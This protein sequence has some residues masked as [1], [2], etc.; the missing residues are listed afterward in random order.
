VLNAYVLA[1][2]GLLLLGAR[3]GDLL[4][5][6][7]TFLAGIALFS[8]GSLAGGLATDS[9]ALLVARAA[10]GAGGALVAPSSLALLTAAFPEGRER[11]RAIGLFTT[12]SAAGGAIGLIAGGL[13]VQWASW[14]WVMFVNVPIGVAVLLAGRRVLTETPRRTGRFDLAGAVLSTLGMT[15]LVLGLVEA[16]SSGW[17]NPLSAGS[18][19]LGLVLLVLFVRNEGRV[20]EPIVPLRLLASP[21]RSAANAARGLV[22]AGMYGVFFFASQYLQDVR[23]YSPLRTGFSFLVMPTTIFLASQLATRTLIGRVRPK[24]LMATGIALAALG[25]AWTSRVQAGTPY[26]EF[27]AGLVVL[28]AGMGLAFVSLTSASL[29]DVPPA[30]AGAASGLVN[31]SQQLGAALGLAAL[32]TVFGDA[33]HHATLQGHGSATDAARALHQLIHGLDSAFVAGTVF[34]LVALAAVLIGVR[35]PARPAVAAQPATR[36][37]AVETEL[38][39]EEALDVTR[40]AKRP[41]GRALG[42]M[43]HPARAEEL[44]GELVELA[45]CEPAPAPDF[46]AA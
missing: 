40:V 37:A 2:G 5:R 32:V 13:L 14:R 25:L 3:S 24:A 30:D 1:F 22:Y 21:T 26:L 41:A 6:R 34:A 35:S 45:G 39:L 15:G 27:E 9:L 46:D 19:A 4:G 16:G 36:D 29:A 38:A 10:Q 28:A 33:T 7:R 43:A 23:G 20:A 12:V 42:G 8:L 17:G 31:V 18:L 44:A 11:L